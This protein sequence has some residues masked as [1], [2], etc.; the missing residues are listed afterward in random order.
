MCLPTSTSSGPAVN[1]FYI[2]DTGPPST[3]LSSHAPDAVVEGM[4]AQVRG[5]GPCVEGVEDIGGRSARGA[6]R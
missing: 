1:V 5:G 4:A 2:L 3:N 6:G